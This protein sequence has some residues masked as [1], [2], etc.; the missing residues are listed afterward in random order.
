[1]MAKTEQKGA[2]AQVAPAE[3]LVLQPEW[4]GCVKVRLTYLT[5]EPVH[6]RNFVLRD[7]ADVDPPYTE[8]IA[9]LLP[10]K[11]VLT[12]LESFMGDFSRLQKAGAVHPEATLQKFTLLDEDV[13]TLAYVM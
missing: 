2:S 4:K 9:V 8:E 3:Q 10:C 1:M 5:P 12:M 7:E 11:R 6:D 13:Y